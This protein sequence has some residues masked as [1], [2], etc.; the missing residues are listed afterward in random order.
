MFYYGCNIPTLDR[1]S[2]FSRGSKWR[3]N[4]LPGLQFAGVSTTEV[5]GQWSK[6]SHKYPPTRSFSMGVGDDR[7]AV[8]LSLCID[9]SFACRPFLAVFRRV[10]QK[11]DH[12]HVC[13]YV[14]YVPAVPQHER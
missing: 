1:G 11:H 12:E 8:S 3:I 9:A 14:V 4:L 7:S 10:L 13:M 6:M 5:T 2:D